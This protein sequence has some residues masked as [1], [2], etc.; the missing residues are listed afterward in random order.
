MN[1]KSSQF[2]VSMIG[3]K[4][5][6]KLRDLPFGLDCRTTSGQSTRQTLLPSPVQIPQTETSIPYTGCTLVRDAHQRTCRYRKGRNV[7]LKELTELLQIDLVQWSKSWIDGDSNMRL[8]E[9]AWLEFRMNFEQESEKLTL[10]PIKTPVSKTT[11]QYL[12]QDRIKR[13][14]W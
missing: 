3:T 6:F 13:L 1:S 10:I 11:D 7:P 4:D 9:W 8:S 5:L 14:L 2:W 12:V